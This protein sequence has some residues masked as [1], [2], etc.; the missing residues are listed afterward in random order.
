MTRQVYKSPPPEAP[1]AIRQGS[2]RA[3]SWAAVVLTVELIA[4]G[5]DSVVINPA[6]LGRGDVPAGVGQFLQEGTMT[7]LVIG[8]TLQALHA[9]TAPPYHT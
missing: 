3:S 9:A 5:M 8:A 2:N 6:H 7:L 1:P 4:L